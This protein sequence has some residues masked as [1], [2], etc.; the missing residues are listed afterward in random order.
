M[1]VIRTG[2][3]ALLAA[4]DEIRSLAPRRVHVTFAGP[5]PY[6]PGSLPDGFVTLDIQPQHWSLDAQGPLGPLV[7]ALATLPV[8]DID[9]RE[10]RLEDILIP[11]YRG[12]A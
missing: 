10:P 12:G 7:A 9:V 5:V 3:L 6:S 2:R 8:Q 1:A 4:V 11:Y